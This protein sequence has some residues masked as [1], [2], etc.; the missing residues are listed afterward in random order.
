LAFA[1]A[2]ALF[3]TFTPLMS[4][5]LIQNTEDRASPGYWL[6][7]A[8]ASGAIASLVIYRKKGIKTFEPDG[9]VHHTPP[10]KS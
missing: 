1:L 6:M 5:I 4:T 10:L 8:A 2:N 7:A 3:G 9:T